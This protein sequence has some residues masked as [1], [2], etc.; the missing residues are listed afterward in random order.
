MDHGRTIL[1]GELRAG[2]GELNR[3]VGAKTFA[4]LMYHL[5]RPVPVSFP[6]GA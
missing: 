1:W 2:V 3:A 4:F 5:T 6:F